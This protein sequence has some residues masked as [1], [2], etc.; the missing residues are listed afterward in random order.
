MTLYL[1]PSARHFEPRWSKMSTW[2][3]H[4]PFAYDLV[5]AIQPKLLVELGTET[6]VSYFAFCQ[7]IKDHE[8]D[9]L[10]Y[11][12][13]TWEGDEHVTLKKSYGKHIYDMVFEY[14]Q[15]CYRDFSYLLRMLFNE[16]LNTF[17]DDSIDLL[18]IDG[19][20]T[21]E[22]VSEDFNSWFPKVKPGGIILMHD[23]T[24]RISSDFGVW[25]FWEEISGNYESFAFRNGYGLGVIRKPGP[26][27]TE[28][29]LLDL[30][31]KSDP[32]EQEQLRAFYAHLRELIEFKRKARFMSEMRKKTIIGRLKS[33]FD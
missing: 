1:P 15:L 3:D 13:D 4:V 5:A 23:I 22:A 7:S 30:L 11:A 27:K 17:S 26:L 2:L 19:Y 10:C 18:H 32:G 20:H 21:Y 6:G 14:N 8:I 12:V 28:S 29:M 16:A 9:A 31:F 33:F 24:A 25:K